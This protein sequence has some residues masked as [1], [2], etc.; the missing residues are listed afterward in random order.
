VSLLTC[1][2]SAVSLIPGDK[3]VDHDW[4]PVRSRVSASAARAVNV[5]K[6]R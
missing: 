5:K 4:S 2:M 6:A 1:M 3:D